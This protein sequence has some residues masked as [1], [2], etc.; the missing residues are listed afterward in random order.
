[1]AVVELYGVGLRWVLMSWE[2]RGGKG[3]NGQVGWIGV[4]CIVVQYIKRTK[5]YNGYCIVG[6][7]WVD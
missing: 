1:M 3:H 4:G 2:L 5:D 7:E 6:F